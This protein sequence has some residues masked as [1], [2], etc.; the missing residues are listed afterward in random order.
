M[1]SI[2][3]LLFLLSAASADARPPL[4]DVPFDDDFGLVFFELSL[5]GS[6]PLA[7]L[8]DTGFDVTAI[9]RDVAERLGLQVEGLKSEAQP[10]GEIETG[11]IAPQSLRIGALEIPEFAL[12]SAPIA[13]LGAIVGRPVEVIVGHDLL[14]R[15][16]VD[17][18]WPHRRLRF[19]EPQGFAHASAGT[20]LPVEIRDS[21][22]L[23]PAGL[24]L[25]GGRSVFGL[26]KLDTGSLDVAGLNLNFV[27]D[28]AIVGPETRELAA[29]GVAVGGETAG[30]LFRAE[31]FVLG[32]LRLPR[33][34]IGYTVDSGGF[35]NRE[36]AGTVGVGWLSR[37]RLILDYPRRRVI[38]EGG[39]GVERPIE[40]DL[41]GLFIVA[42][43]P[44]RLMVAQVLPGSPGADAGIAPGDEIVG[45]AGGAAPSLAAVRQA[46]R[47]PGPVE[48]V[49]RREGSADREL[50]LERRAYLP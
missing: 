17:I 49:V 12:T 29:G 36:D 24:V 18:D 38:L 23:V 15:F 26:F 13:G 22:P 28:Q 30:R 47:Q 27:R 48:I 19:L 34:V 8:L 31:A 3:A 35:E 1:Q 45:F 6:E 10:G 32:D 25:S 7:A 11:R 46:L 41:S 9:D 42:P 16:V 40:E 43:Q 37:F 4:A 50:R 44:S 2:A 21:E 39:P 20:V 14:E 5:A 33:P